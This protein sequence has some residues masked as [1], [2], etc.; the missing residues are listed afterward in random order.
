MKEITMH[1]ETIFCEFLYSFTKDKRLFAEHIK[2]TIFESLEG[3][4]QIIDSVIRKGKLPKSVKKISPLR[5]YK[6][7]TLGE[8]VIDINSHE[9][10]ATMM[11]FVNCKP[12]GN[13]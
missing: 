10:M 5:G 7:P 2:E 12:M 9:E 1:H 8:D 13:A 4:E 11:H 6:I 3:L